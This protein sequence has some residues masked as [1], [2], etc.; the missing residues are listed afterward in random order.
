MSKM[1]TVALEL[2]E[3][4]NEMGFETIQDALDAG[5]MAD[6][7]T[8]TWE[9]VMDERHKEYVRK[10]DR[11]VEMMKRDFAEYLKGK[12]DLNTLEP[13]EFYGLAMRY[14]ITEMVEQMDEDDAGLID[15][16]LTYEHPL[17]RAWEA[18]L[19]FEEDPSLWEQLRDALKT[20]KGK[21]A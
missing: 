3:R 8:A 10:A 13:H 1:G 15:V 2:Q 11:L 4:A 18:W 19:H 12:G 17:E 6:L 7:D 21:E 14:E 20:I 5:Y 16:L 9:K